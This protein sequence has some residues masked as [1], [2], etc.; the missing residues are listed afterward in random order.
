MKTIG[1]IFS[2]EPGNF[3]ERVY[4]DSALRKSVAGR[5]TPNFNRLAAQGISF[6]K[7]YCAVPACNPS[8]ASL[9]TGIRPHVSGFTSN[10]DAIFFRDYEY[11]GEKPLADAVTIAEHL[12]NNGWYTFLTG[13]LFHEA[14][15]YAEADGQ[16]SW[17]DWTTILE[18]AGAVTPSPWS[19]QKFSWGQEGEE[20]TRYQNLNDYRRADFVARLLEN[21]AIQK[22]DQHFELPQNQPFF[23][24]CG[25][26]RPHLPF[27]ATK[28]LL[29]LFPQDE[30]SVSREMFNELLQ[31]SND[32]PDY[33]L[34]WTRLGK[35]GDNMFINKGR[36]APIL[37]QGLSVDPINGDLRGWKDMLQHYFASTAI[38]DRSV[39]RLL[40]GLEQSPYKDNTVVIVWSDHGFH[41]GEKMHFTKFTLWEDAARTPFFIF[42]PRAQD[43]RGKRCD[44]PVSLMDL[45]PTICRIA[46]LELPDTRITG[47]DLTPLIKDPETTRPSLALVTFDDVN[48]NMISYNNSKYIQYEDGSSELYELKTDP[49]ELNNL[50]ELPEYTDLKD[51]MRRLLEAYLNKN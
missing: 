28:D 40:D 44:Q 48:N 12:K 10:S 49:E 2:E 43:S 51:R 45:Y 23:L 32:L 3:L 6:M 50:A 47:N 27:N 14:N 25:I 20:D 31:D 7:A 16:R 5:M 46:G 24:A 18:G 15:V 34:K 8:R 35:S 9:M 4:P 21:G 22:E 33:A 19:T 17:S 13:K 38:A 37:K 39:G 26:S 41:L 36:F 30:M 1:S 29:D 42:D 11:D